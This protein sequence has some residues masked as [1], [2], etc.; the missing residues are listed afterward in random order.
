MKREVI[1]GEVFDKSD[2]TKSDAVHRDYAAHFFR[3]SFALRYVNDKTHVL[4]VGC[5]SDTPMAK[6]IH[7]RF[8]G[9]RPA[10]YVGVDLGRLPRAPNYRQW[11]TFLP[12][13]DFT[14]RWRELA[15]V[16]RP[17][18][19]IVCFEAIEHMPVAAGARLLAGARQ[20]LA[21]DGVMLLSTPVFNGRAAKNHIHEYT[22]P[23]LERA[24]ARAGLAVERRCGTFASY[25]A[26][27]KA[28]GPEE[29]RLLNELR[30]YY[31]DEVAACFLAPKYPDAARNNLW[32]LR[33]KEARDENVGGDHAGGGLAR[34]R[35]DELRD[36]AG[37]GRK[38]TPRT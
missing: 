17:F 35:S 20:L 38:G 2:L 13:F 6:A 25:P 36:S 29:L 8:T 11:A 19:L 23:E 24:I 21:H 10:S 14:R 3:W 30:T 37:R 33:R 28:C 27:K 22:I 1:E 31:D 4:D 18:D 5:G 26:M 32:V 12:E 9:K 34:R 16:Y 15:E 7:W